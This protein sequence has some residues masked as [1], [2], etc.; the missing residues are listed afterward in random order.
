MQ[1]PEDPGQDE[2]AWFD[3]RGGDERESGSGEPD[4]NVTNTD[5]LTLWWI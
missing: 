3:E 2:V 1:T 5:R 4:Q